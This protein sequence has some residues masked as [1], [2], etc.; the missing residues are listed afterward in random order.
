MSNMDNKKHYIW[1]LAASLCRRNMTM[2]GKD[3]ASRLNRNGYLTES[4]HKYA[5]GRGTYK[6]INEACKWLNNKQ[7]LPEEAK[8]VARAF[9]KP[10]GTYAYE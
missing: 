1:R 10:D 8:K 3:L 6:L 5:G 4:G 9:K 7:K 2:S